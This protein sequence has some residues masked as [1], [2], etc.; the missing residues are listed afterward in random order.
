MRGK[1]LISV[2]MIVLMMAASVSVL[3]SCGSKEEEQEKTLETY[4]EES[5]DGLSELEKINESLTNEDMEGSISV[6]D[7]EINMTL[8]LKQAVDKSYYDVMEKTVTDMMEEY[9]SDFRDA[10]SS[11]EEESGV[12]GITMN[13]DLLN[14]DGT[15]IC[16]INID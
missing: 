12:S 4:L 2:L 15:E 13:F 11:I 9:K 14:A 8:T 3:A 5:E 6:K 10:V 1:R 16:T 7:N